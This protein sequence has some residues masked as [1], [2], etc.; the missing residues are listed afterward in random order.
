MWYI[1]DNRGSDD[2]AVNLALE[3]YVLRNER[4]IERYMLIYRNRPAVIIGKHQ[5]VAEEVN[6]RYCAEKGIPILRRLYGGGAVYHDYGNINFSFIT[7]RSLKLV[8]NYAYFIKPLL[9]MLRQMG[10]DAQTDARSNIITNGVKI[11]GNAQFTS[12]TRMLSHGTLLYEAD[13]PILHHSLQVSS[14]IKIKSKSSKSVHSRVGNLREILP[15]APSVRDFI[16]EVIE[17]YKAIPFE[18]NNEDWSN[19]K[20]LAENTYRSAEW[21]FDRSPASQIQCPL[22]DKSGTAQIYL[23]LERGHIISVEFSGLREQGSEVAEALRIL[24]GIRFDYQSL[25]KNRT[26]WLAEQGWPEILFD[27]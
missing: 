1:I 18:L 7:G 27:Q 22:G 14:R 4:L 24:I 3:E 2:P 26:S 9:Q 8:N 5:N 6:L 23:L 12:R 20:R 16:N 19:I 13:L 11:S 17:T 15:A 10:T 25:L 21:N